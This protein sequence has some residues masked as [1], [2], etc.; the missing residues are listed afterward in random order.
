M[1]F[2][3]GQ[4]KRPPHGQA[5]KGPSDAKPR[6]FAGPER[7]THPELP[8]GQARKTANIIMAWAISQPHFARSTRERLPEP[9]GA[10]VKP[11]AALPRCATPGFGPDT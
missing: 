6:P 5:G 2:A 8:E 7:E 1:S 11:A 3:I 10:L 9:K 4:P